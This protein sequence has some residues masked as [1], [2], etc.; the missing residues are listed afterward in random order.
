ML[1]I[2]ITVV[3]MMN[4]YKVVKNKIVVLLSYG[5]VIHRLTTI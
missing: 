5:L 3:K 2:M 4:K 1:I